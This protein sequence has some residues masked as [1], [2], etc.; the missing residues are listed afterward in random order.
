MFCTYLAIVTKWFAEC[1]NNKD[2]V[3][4]LTDDDLQTAVAIRPFH[5]IL[6]PVCFVSPSNTFHILM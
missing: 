2:A 6:V 5:I 3:Y 4:K 1:N